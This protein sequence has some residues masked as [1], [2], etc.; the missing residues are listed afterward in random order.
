MWFANLKSNFTFKS[1]IF[2]AGDLKDRARSLEKVLGRMSIF[3]CWISFCVNG[4]TDLLRLSVMHLEV[5]KR[6]L[7]PVTSLETSHLSNHLQ[8]VSGWFKTWTSSGKTSV[9]AN[10]W[11]WQA[12]YF[13]WLCLAHWELTSV[14]YL[15]ESNER[16][17]ASQDRRKRRYCVG[18]YQSMAQLHGRT[19]KKGEC[20]SRS[21]D[22]EST[23][24]AVLPL[25]LP[26][27]RRSQTTTNVMLRW[28]VMVHCITIQPVST[29]RRRSSCSAFCTYTT[30]ISSFWW[31]WWWSSVHIIR[32]FTFTKFTFTFAF[33]FTK[34]FRWTTQLARHK[35]S[36]HDDE[37]PH[38][39]TT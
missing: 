31:W 16:G 6:W 3:L 29:C 30:L 10:D 26:S 4:S 8:T 37:W 38:Q 7:H 5:Y 20:S 22:N 17:G 1:K 12:D 28:Q 9:R 33:T 11:C 39:I 2:T 14:H 35:R 25:V 34:C 24:E 21:A 18:C 32:W 15:R 27:I 23:Q 19:V 36:N 13:G